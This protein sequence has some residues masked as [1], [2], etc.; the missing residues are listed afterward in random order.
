METVVRRLALLLLLAPACAPD[1]RCGLRACDIRTSACQQSAAS[2]AACL[3]GQQPQ[4]IPIETVSRSHYVAGEISGSATGDLAAEQH[5][6]DAL[7]LIDLA[8]PGVTPQSA[9]AS[10]SGRVAAYYSPAAKKITVITDDG[11]NTPLDG[12]WNVTLL[13]HESTHALQDAAGRLAYPPGDEDRSYDRGMALD[14]LIE[15]EASLTETLARLALFEHDVADVPWQRLFTQFDDLVSRIAA[16]APVP[17]DLA[18]S[19]F[20]YPYGLTATY[21]AYAADGTAGLDRLWATPPISARAVILGPDAPELAAGPVVEDLGPDSVPKD[22]GGLIYL[23]GDRT[24]AFVFRLFVMR[25]ERNAG[26]ALA[27]SRARAL[28]ADLSGDYLSLFTGGPSSTSS[29]VSWRLRFSTSEAADRAEAHLTALRPRVV[30]PGSPVQ[31]SVLRKDR[32][33]VI[34]TPKLADGITTTTWSAPPAPVI[35]P[36]VPSAP[37]TPERRVICLPPAAGLA[38]QPARD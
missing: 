15:G 23:D 33:V 38:L 19:Y 24:G 25:A 34:F 35:T 37:G 1:A 30:R 21:R 27:N 5:R 3:L 16:A 26:V 9:T 36:A 13:V 22:T 2:A 8:D 6:L 18:F 4:N 32:D 14:A 7:M 29:A 11:D 12:A 28:G 17:I 20:A 31:W 10:L